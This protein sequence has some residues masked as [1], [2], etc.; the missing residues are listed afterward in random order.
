MLICAGCEHFG[1]GKADDVDKYSYAATSWV[2]SNIQEMVA[3]WPHA[4]PSCG[5]RK[6][7]AYG[8]VWWRHR[9]I[10]KSMHSDYDCEAIAYYDKAGVITDVDVKRS[11]D[12]HRLFERHFDRM[13][14][15]W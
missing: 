2:G 9:N 5:S 6:G 1:D 15:P 10:T 7:G 13:T 4:M 12:C 8:C 11:R 14:W 3:A